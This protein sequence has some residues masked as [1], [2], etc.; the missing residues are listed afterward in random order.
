MLAQIMSLLKIDF[1]DNCDSNG[2]SSRENSIPLTDTFLPF[3]QIDD[4][5][6]VKA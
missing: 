2:N 1:N 6:F 3:Y 5:T 4:S